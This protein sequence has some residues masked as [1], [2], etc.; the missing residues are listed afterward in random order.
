MLL[1]VFR[2]HLGFFLR[3]QLPLGF[4]GAGLVLVHRNGEVV[5]VVLVFEVVDVVVLGVVDV[6]DDVEVELVVDAVDI[7]VGAV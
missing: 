1:D 3:R 7:A 2:G 6:V 4:N 5:V